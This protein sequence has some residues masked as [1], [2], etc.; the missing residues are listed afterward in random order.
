MNVVS[1][2]KDLMG[3]DYITVYEVFI[4]SSINNMLELE[5]AVDNNDHRGIE[6]MS[7]TLKGSAANIG[8]HKFS[9]LSQNMMEYARNGGG[10]EYKTMLLQ[11]NEEFVKLKTSILELFE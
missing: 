4:R 3:E 8:G 5:E 11:L 1:N 10:N 2:L 9:S 6:K 7:H